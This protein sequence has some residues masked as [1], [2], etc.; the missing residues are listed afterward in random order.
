MI[1]WSKISE[2]GVLA[3]LQASLI[4]IIACA[5]CVACSRPD[6]EAKMQAAL[7][8]YYSGHALWDK[9]KYLDA[10]EQY[11]KWEAYQEEVGEDISE[12]KGLIGHMI[13]LGGGDLAAA[14]AR[15]DSSL[16]MTFR[17]T[18]AVYKM[19]LLERR[20]GVASAVA[21]LHGQNLSESVEEE[22][23]A[24]F[25]LSLMR[26]DEALPYLLSRFQREGGVSN[27]AADLSY[28]GGNDSREL[29]ATIAECY[30]DAGDWGEAFKYATMAVSRSQYTAREV[31]GWQGDR[32]L[33]GSVRAR[34]VRARVFCHRAD[35][36]AAAEECRLAKIIIDGGTYSERAGELQALIND[37]E[38]RRG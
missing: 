4:G 18:V 25:W 15:I 5:L 38:R 33:A 1:G 27:Y 2:S 21:W 34:L 35:W 12:V 32:A 14:Q 6:D 13:S 16:S 37:I 11:A 28:L 24:E 19:R 7:A 23:L 36:S 31:W 30:L 17:P 9:G 22:V 29:P 20:D 10:A 3:P 26:C 8:A